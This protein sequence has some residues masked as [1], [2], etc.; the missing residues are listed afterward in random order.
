MA[1]LFHA[2]HAF[3]ALGFEFVNA[4]VLRHTRTERNASRTQP[5]HC[6]VVFTHRIIHFRIR[7]RLVALGYSV[8]TSGGSQQRPA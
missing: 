7:P 5:G 3:T 6:A 4:L 2:C 8:L 1:L